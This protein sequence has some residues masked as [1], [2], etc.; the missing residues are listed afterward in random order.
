MPGGQVEVGEALDDA[1]TREVLEETGLTIEPVGITGVYYNTTKHILSVVFKAKYI[2]GEV[3]IQPEEISEAKFIA[4][5]DENIDQYITRPHM[6]SR[7]LDAMH[8]KN[9][10]PYET[11]TVN[12]YQLV[13]RMD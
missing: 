8:A 6:R 2:G 7:A 5:N 4:I 10:I 12:P 13:G 11:W 1:V 9:S 3:K